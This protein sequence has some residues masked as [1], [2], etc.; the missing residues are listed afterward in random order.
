MRILVGI[1]SCLLSIS[2]IAATVTASWQHD[3]LHV[4]GFR[5]DYQCQTQTGSVPAIASARSL[6]FSAP[7]GETCLASMVAYNDVAESESSSTV[8]FTTAALPLPG[9]VTNLRISWTEQGQVVADFK[10]QRGTV[11][12]GAGATTATITAGSEYTAPASTAKA[13]IRIVSHHGFTNGDSLSDTTGIPGRNTAY[14]SNPSNLLTS[15]TFSRTDTNTVNSTAIEWE[16]IEYIGAASG[17]NEFIVRDVGA[18]AAGTGATSI[19]GTT[20]VTHS[21]A[22]DIAVFVTGVGV[23]N[24]ARGESGPSSWTAS[25]NTTTDGAEFTRDLTQGRAGNVSYAVVEFTGS[26]WAVQ[27]VEH[28]QSA[29]GSETETITSVGDVSRAFIHVQHAT[30]TVNGPRQMG[31]EVHLSS[32]TQLTFDVDVQSGARRFVAWVVSNSQTGTGAMSVARYSGTRAANTG[33]D[34][35]SFTQA[36]TSVSDVEQAS[37]M[38]EC[39]NNGTATTDSHY[40]MLGFRLT[41]VDTV[42]MTR[43]RNA[44]SRDY[45][46]EVVQWPSTVSGGTT[47]DGAVEGIALTTFPATIS[48]D[49]A[50]SA[51]VEQI[52]LSTLPSSIALDIGIN[53]VAEQITLSTFLSAI[54]SDRVILGAIESI[55]LQTHAAT[56]S[57]GSAIAARTEQ[58]QVTTNPALVALDISLDA[59]LQQIVLTSLSAQIGLAQNID[60]NLESLTLT[61]HGATLTLDSGIAAQLE[62]LTLQTFMASISSAVPE[63]DSPG[64]QYTLAGDRAHYTLPVSRLHFTF[65]S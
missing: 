58:I 36:I 31:Y 40:S 2:S 48:S 43:G 25:F 62:A 27:R 38:G 60:A 15:I 1:L 46:F 56:I 44:N 51:V 10:V 20:S 47:V 17:A 55:E 34:P 33:S 63:F 28:S 39:A 52:S 12:I 42:T 18:V 61:T 30:N 35:D 45:R 29:A 4:D 49:R 59:Q 23:I 50:I 9:A 11:T 7:D 21:D 16:I 6:S 3:G 5:L 53:A 54:S 57:V 24:G 41:A 37:I 26:N 65:R 32:T 14:V 13:F 8:Q 64:L 22:A 19:A